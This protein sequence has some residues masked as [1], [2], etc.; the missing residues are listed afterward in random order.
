MTTAGPSPSVSVVV[1]NY[2]TAGL[3]LR[4]AASV[5]DPHAQLLVVDNNSQD[6]SVAELRASGLRVLERA[7][8]DGFAAAVNDGM[9]HTTGPVVVMLNADTE[10]RPGAVSALVDHLGRHPDVGVAAPVLLAP[11]GRRIA[12]AYRRFPDAGILFLELCVPL[13]YLVDRYPALDPYRM[14]AQDWRAGRSVAHVQGAAMAIR[15]EAWEASGGLAERY[16]LYLEET[17]WQAR[18]RD[19]GWTVEVVPTAEV[20][21]IGRSG[22]PSAAPAV[23]FLRSAEVYLRDRGMPRARAVALMATAVTLSRLTLRLL[24]LLPRRAPSARVMVTS[25]DD[26]W[27]DWWPPRRDPA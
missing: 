19:I 4:C 3:A 6:G 9:R 1:V 17:E 13:G 27:R 24:S 12:A 14:R 10:L 7:H 2:R 16:F 20:V 11:D 18:L 5:D 8:N 22:Q 15:R 23:H 25:W 21:H 26:L